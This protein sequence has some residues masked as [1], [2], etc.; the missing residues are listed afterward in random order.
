MP[1]RF[2]AGV[3]A[4]LTVVGVAGP[5]ARRPAGQVPTL[6]TAMREKLANTQQL[7]E[8]VV[9][10]NYAEMTRYSELLSRISYTEIASWQAVAQPDYVR[11]ATQFLAS[12]KGVSDAASRRNAD[13]AAREY[14]T[15]VGTCVG[16]HAYVRNARTASLA[17]LGEPGRDAR[18]G[19]TAP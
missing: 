13:E 7:L 8:A 17:P 4:L 15:L 1:L 9:T 12:V 6:R 19:R 18:M 16:C 11:H 3:L 5:G 2:N 10:A 14:T